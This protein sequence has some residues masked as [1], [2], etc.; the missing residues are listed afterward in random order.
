M[1]WLCEIG[2]LRAGALVTWGSAERKLRT[3][4]LPLLLAHHY[5]RILRSE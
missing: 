2:G 5:L 3:A 1:S 4:T